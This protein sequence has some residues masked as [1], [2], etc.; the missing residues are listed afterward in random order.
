[1]TVLQTYAAGCAIWALL[2]LWAATT[3]PADVVRHL[4]VR[5]AVVS[6]IAWPVALM[7]L[8]SMRLGRRA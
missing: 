4:T 7:L 5:G 3:A 8:I 6:A 1:M 2:M